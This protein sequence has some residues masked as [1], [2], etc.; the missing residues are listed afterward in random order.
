MSSDPTITG[1]GIRPPILLA[2]AYS[3]DTAE[4]K[5][6]AKSDISRPIDENLFKTIELVERKRELEKARMKS[7]DY[8]SL[9]S[10]IVQS[11]PPFNAKP[12]AA[13][14]TVPL[15]G[16]YVCSGRQV[17]GPDL[18]EYPN[19]NSKV[20]A[21]LKDMNLRY[22]KQEPLS[23]LGCIG[24]T[25]LSYRVYKNASRI[26][27]KDKKEETVALGLTLDLFAA[28]AAGYEIRKSILNHSL[29]SRI[30]K[31]NNLIRE[32][33][34]AASRHNE[35][36][37]LRQEEKAAQIDLKKDLLA[38]IAE[39][40]PLNNRYMT[41]DI[42]TQTLK[43]EMNGIKTALQELENNEN[44]ELYMGLAEMKS[45]VNKL[46]GRAREI[47]RF[48]AKREALFE[49]FSEMNKI[50]VKMLS[51]LNMSYVT[52]KTTDKINELKAELSGLSKFTYPA[53][54]A[55]NDNIDILSQR[56][57]WKNKADNAIKRANYEHQ[58]AIDIWA[59]AKEVL[60]VYANILHL[61]SLEKS[62][63]E[64]PLRNTFE[65]CT[66]TANYAKL[67]ADLR[68]V[69]IRIA[70][71]SARL[72]R[73]DKEYKYLFSK[74]SKLFDEQFI[75]LL[76]KLIELSDIAPR[77]DITD[78]TASFRSEVRGEVKLFMVHVFI[79]DYIEQRQRS[80]SN[81]TVRKTWFGDALNP[82]GTLDLQFA[83][84]DYEAIG[85]VVKKPFENVRVGYD[86]TDGN[87]HWYQKGVAVFDEHRTLREFVSYIKHI[88]KA[89][90]PLFE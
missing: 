66:K 17:Y 44:R 8:R 21:E 58:T 89:F 73:V 15:F 60:N 46:T 76:G 51:D 71:S 5:E 47:N 6:E 19:S 45:K 9:Y 18:S 54:F 72:A 35:E 61:N 75:F 38:A 31:A 22:E 67:K 28:W 27:N 20:V 30:E 24:F 48:C 56:N 41:M 86:G 83:I 36:V 2:Q 68:K 53:Y 34:A 26:N 63:A 88:V 82:D 55:E 74:E 81:L 87:E 57:V 59:G 85:G 12:T 42:F 16:G 64:G 78:E 80:N 62:A 50:D 40:I 33:N 23:W 37:K 49:E 1:L 77:K 14:D 84:R 52:T 69:I 10:Y 13:S 29:D 32:Y 65:T 3:R 90:K 7:T 25:Y 4:N 70:E 39:C 43:N 11:E 79:N